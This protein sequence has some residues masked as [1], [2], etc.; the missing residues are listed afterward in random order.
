MIDIR[1]SELE[2]VGVIALGGELTVAHAQELRTSLKEVVYGYRSVVVQFGDIADVDLS[3]LQL[4]CSA[5]KSAMK[6]EKAFALGE[7]VPA[8]FAQLFADAGFIRDTGCRLDPGETCLW[9][10]EATHG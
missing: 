5:H 8:I 3:C 10:K 4:L 7:H 9:A 2:G 6:Q 1:L